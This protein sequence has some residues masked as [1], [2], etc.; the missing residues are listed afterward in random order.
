[1]K[2]VNIM[3]NIMNNTFAV[4]PKHVFHKPHQFKVA[5]SVVMKKINNDSFIKN[6]VT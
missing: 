6:E 5:W 3:T 2:G 1:M 4:Q